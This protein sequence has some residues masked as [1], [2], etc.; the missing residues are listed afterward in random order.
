MTLGWHEARRAA[1]AAAVPLPPVEVRPEEALGATLAAPLTARGAVPGF[2]CSAMDGYAVG[3]AAGPWR[4]TGRLLAGDRARNP[5][6]QGEAVVIATGAPVP[7][8][9]YA[10][11]P[12]E[13]ACR[14]GDEVTAAGPTGAGRHVRRTG[15]DVPAGAELLPG[16]TAVTATVVGLAAHVGLDA[17]T[18]RR[19]PAVAALLTGAELVTT[20]GSADGSVRDSVGPAMPGWVTA[21]GGEPLPVR[22]VPETGPAALTEAVRAARADVVVTSGG[23]GGG[24]A[25][26][27]RPALRELGATTVVDG[28]LCRPGRPQRLSLLPDGT[29]LVAL[30]GNPYA[31]L[32]AVLT[33]LGPLLAGLAGRPLPTLP[34]A[35]LTRQAA[36]P[37]T[38]IVPVRWDGSTVV[39]T[40]RDGP[41]TLWGAARADAFAVV[42]PGHRD[43]GTVELLVL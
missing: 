32:V 21:L 43:G 15:E 6:T 24:P 36:G 14:D 18:V 35:A 13:H 37:G 38:R 23:A 22:Y 33:L 10:V 40:G 34:A 29:P 16:G 25:D 5:L 17:V 41:G 8:G 27:V 4:V 28:V 1:Y 26:Q 7:P 11:L 42:P 2:D 20:G 9:T 19:R 31:A 39:P 3:S 30:P 12:D